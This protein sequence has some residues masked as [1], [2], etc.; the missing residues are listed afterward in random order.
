MVDDDD[1]LAE[2]LDADLHMSVGSCALARTGDGDV[3][4]LGNLRV[5]SYRD[6]RR[7][8][9]RRKGLGCNAVSGNTALAEPFVT[10]AHRLHGEARRAADADLRIA[11]GR[12]G[13]VVQ[14]AQPL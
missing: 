13:A 9:E 5:T 4:R 2:L 11:G 1:G 12:R 3:H 7:R 14:A 8:V 10:A 6:Q